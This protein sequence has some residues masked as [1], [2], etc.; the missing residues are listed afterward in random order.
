MIASVNYH[1]DLFIQMLSLGTKGSYYNYVHVS[2]FDFGYIFIE[3]FLIIN[4]IK[5][6]FPS[7]RNDYNSHICFTLAEDTQR[8]SAS[9]HCFYSWTEAAVDIGFVLM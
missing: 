1:T 7:L 4:I 6:K 5:K 9:N 3:D 8:V 2:Q